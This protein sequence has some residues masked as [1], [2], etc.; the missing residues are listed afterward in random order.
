MNIFEFINNIK[1]GGIL[2]PFD[3][4]M[5]LSNF[6]KIDIPKIIDLYDKKIEDNDLLELDRIIRERLK[7]KPI[8]KIFNEKYFWNYSFFVN[9]NVLDPRPDSEIMIEEILKTYKNENLNVLDL[10]TGSGCLIITILKLFSNF[11][12]TGVDISEKALE[13]A[14]LN[15][16]NL[17]VNN[18]IKFIK[19]NWNDGINEKF[20]IIISNPPYIE[21]DFIEKLDIDVR[22]YDPILALDGG[23]DGLDCYKYLAENLKKNCKHST[24]IFLEIGINQKDNIIKIFEKNNFKF[25]KSAKD[26][27]SI[28]RILVFSNLQNN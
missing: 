12:G 5:I 7:G 2:P 18:R 22:E 19:N 3:V 27:G 8:S 1:K 20:D 26:Y 4:K 10:G 14:K 13:V 23:K 15:S 9:E 25:E 16:N 24:K 6:Y 11:K 17:N 28:E 21:T